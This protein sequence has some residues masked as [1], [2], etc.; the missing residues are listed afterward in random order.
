MISKKITDKFFDKVSKDEDYGKVKDRLK[1][2]LS[3]DKLEVEEILTILETEYETKE[4]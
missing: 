4:S 1:L 2:W 3:E